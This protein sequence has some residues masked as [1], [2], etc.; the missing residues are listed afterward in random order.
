MH[1][2]MTTQGVW[3]DEAKVPFDVPSDVHSDSTDMPCGV[4]LQ[5]YEMPWLFKET[6]T[7]TL[8]IH[9]ENRSLIALSKCRYPKLNI[10]TQITICIK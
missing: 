1:Y 5:Q 9:R 2:K 7:K 10:Y 6:K 4:L 8:F 3:W